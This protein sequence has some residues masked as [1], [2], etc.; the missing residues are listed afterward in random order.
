[1]EDIE[2]VARLARR[3]CALLLDGEGISLQQRVEGLTEILPRVWLAGAVL[4]PVPELPPP[5]AGPSI[6]AWPGLGRFD[7]EAE[8]P[9]SEALGIVEAWLWSGLQFYD[10]GDPAGALTV[11][12]GGYPTWSVALVGMLPVLHGAALRFRPQPQ[13]ERA[14]DAAPSLVMVGS[15]D[16]GEAA[17]VAPPAPAVKP[18]LGVRFEA[19]G[20][21]AYI[22]E[23]HPRSP[24]ASMLQAGDVVLAV[25]DVSLEHVDP[26]ILAE[27]MVG[28]VG[29]VRTY[30]VYRDGQA[31]EVQ[32]ASVSVSDLRGPDAE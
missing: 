25:D 2:R 10:E 9:L 22:V 7:D 24:A 14:R 5:P 28:P 8:P 30:V 17:A 1:M 26:A 11:W 4:P 3:L 31:G 15:A 21:G 23:V 12:A 27:R 20:L 32:F 29:E 19:I 13:L 16:G 6:E 18:A